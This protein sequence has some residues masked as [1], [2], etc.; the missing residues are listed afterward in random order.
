[1][2]SANGSFSAD[3]MDNSGFAVNNTGDFSVS[4]MNNSGDFIDNGSS[5][6]GSMNNSGDVTVKG[7]GSDYGS[8]ANSGSM[9]VSG[10]GN[11]FSSVTNSGSISLGGSGN[12][13]GALGN[14]GEFEYGGSN[15]IGSIDNSG[16]G[17]IYRDGVIWMM[18]TDEGMNPEF[19]SD[20][21]NKNFSVLSHLTGILDADLLDAG[22]VST[23]D[24]LMPGRYLSDSH[25]RHADMHAVLGSD[26]DLLNIDD[27]VDELIH[28]SAPELDEEELLDILS[29]N[30]SYQDEFDAAV[31]E[32]IEE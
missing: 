31:N 32:V 20:G 7:Y 16:T 25:V 9:I 1:M 12:S 29:G 18:A 4:S 23:F 30:E 8:V 5:S 2:V 24:R 17:S 22:F 21:T 6:I 26:I 27:A 13:V 14:S 3:S 10:S 19:Y 11:D 28:G 15:M